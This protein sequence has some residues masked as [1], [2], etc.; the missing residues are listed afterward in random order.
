MT[1]LL[2]QIE[3]MRLQVNELANGEHKLFSGLNDALVY[4]DYGLVHEV[5]NVATDHQQRR[6]MILDE[7]RVLSLRIGAVPEQHEPTAA[8]AETS[9]DLFSASLY[10]EEQSS[11]DWWPHRQ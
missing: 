10:R 11:G 3:E 4:A 5:R 7:L 9:R 8:L 2:Q 1:T 6:G